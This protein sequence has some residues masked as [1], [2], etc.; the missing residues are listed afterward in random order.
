M[1]AIKKITL[2]SNGD[3]YQILFTANNK[4]SSIIKSLFKRN[5]IKI[6]KVGKIIKKRGLQDYSKLKH[7]P[8]KVI[9]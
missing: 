5:N 1:K 6:T 3:D 4:N 7:T 9:L 2:V 8:R